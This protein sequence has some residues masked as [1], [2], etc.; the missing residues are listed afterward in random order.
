[1]NVKEVWEDLLASLSVTQK[2]M[3]RASQPKAASPNGLV[4]AFDYEIICKK[5]ANDQDFV[6]AVQNN[7]SRMISDYVPDLV[8]I[9]DESWYTLRQE[10]LSGHKDEAD[11]DELTEQE[12]S[13]S[14]TTDEQKEDLAVSKAQDLF[15][16]L[17]TIKED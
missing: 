13:E 10:F 15:G 17:A 11:E 2:A 8:Y 7:I 4:I 6:L 14:T 5:A 16:E 3:L 1:M 9:T 12:E